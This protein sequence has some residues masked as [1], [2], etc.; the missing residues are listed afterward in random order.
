MKDR[1]SQAQA[2]AR[3]SLREIRW[4]VG[5]SYALMRS[6]I[7]WSAESAT[8]VD[9]YAWHLEGRMDVIGRIILSVMRD[10]GTSF[11]L[12]AL[13][14]DELNDQHASDGRNAW[15][16]SGPAVALNAAAAE[17]MGLLFYELV[18]N[19]IE[20]GALGLDEGGELRVNWQ[21][22]PT[23]EGG[24]AMLRLEWIERGMPA[25]L[26]REGF[27]S[28]VLEEMLRYQL[29][30]AAEREFDANGVRIRLAVPMRN[31]VREHGAPASD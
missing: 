26:N 22:D 18:A 8:S 11:D 15:S 29:D 2:D 20:H 30:G 7:R 25:R 23:G 14:E 24:G 3:S 16:L 19:S 10:S 27:G 31:L 6:I 21:V 4:Q 5:N 9:S 12:C 17:V 28:M 13:I 1:D